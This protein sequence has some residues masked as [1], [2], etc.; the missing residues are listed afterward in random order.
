MNIVFVH[1]VIVSYLQAEAEEGPSKRE[2]WMT[3]LPPEM[4]KNFGLQ[5]R[6][7]TK[8]G[9]HSEDSKDRSSWTDTPSVKKEKV[10]STWKK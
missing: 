1:I 8:G 9:D 3:E 10:L 6:T 7:F 4:G 2:E 5:S